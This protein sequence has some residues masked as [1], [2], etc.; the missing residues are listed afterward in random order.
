M[1]KI[2]KNIMLFAGC[3]WATA[4]SAAIVENQ[5]LDFGT[6]GLR[7][8]AGVY[9]YVI[10]PNGTISTDFE[11]VVLSDGVPGDYSVSGF[12]ASTTLTF[13][14]LGSSPL[15][16][17]GT[18][19]GVPFP[20]NNFTI[21]PNPIVTDPA[22]NANFTMGGT[23]TTDGLGTMYADGAYSDDVLIVVSF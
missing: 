17:G 18:G 20:I 6:F 7:D 9:S 19:G 22:G 14:V 23:I 3:L 10:A 2:L 1:G 12:P 11:I 8:N 13:Q 15:T 4:A 5:A 21:N 16:L